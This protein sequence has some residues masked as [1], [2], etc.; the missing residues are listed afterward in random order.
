MLGHGENLR[1]IERR[2]S[3]NRKH[4]HVRLF[5][6]PLRLSQVIATVVVAAIRDNDYGTAL[7]LRLALR[8]SYSQIDPIKKRGSPLGGGQKQRESALKV[9]L[10]AGEGHKTSGSGF[11][12]QA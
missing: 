7:I 2:C 11:D 9:V 6:K 1:K 5:Q 4:R 8:R 3:H 12:S 10:I